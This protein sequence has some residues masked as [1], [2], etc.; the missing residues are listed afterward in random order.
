[1]FFLVEIGAFEL[2]VVEA[3]SFVFEV[4]V[5]AFVVFSFPF[6]VEGVTFAGFSIIFDVGLA[7][8]VFTSEKS[9]H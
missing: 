1:M 5:V 4:E 3:F 7:F 9:S 6:D 2:D 8:V